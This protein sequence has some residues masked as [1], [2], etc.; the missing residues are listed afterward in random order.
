ME[1]LRENLDTEALEAAEEDI[2]IAKE[3]W[4][5]THMQVSGEVV[6]RQPW[7]D[8]IWFVYRKIPNKRPPPNRRP[9]SF[10]QLLI[11]KK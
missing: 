4:E 9:P 2:T 3:E 8:I 1:K 7:V 11:T 10:Y 5:L 6:T